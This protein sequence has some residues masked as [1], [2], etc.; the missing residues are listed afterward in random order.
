MK[1]TLIL[2]F[3]VFTAIGQGIK[4]TILD[5][6]TQKPLENVTIYYDKEKTGTASDKKGAFHLKTI[7]T[8]NPTDSIRFSIIG[9]TQKNYTLSTLNKLNFI[10]HLATITESLDEV[11]IT[12]KQHLN[13]TIAYKNLSP[14]VNGVYNFDATIIGNKIYII[15]GNETHFEDLG[16]RALHEAVSLDDFL[17][18]LKTN[19]TWENYSDKLQIYDIEKDTWNTLKLT[20][21][22]RANHSIAFLNNKIYVLGGKTLS[23]NR[24]REYLDDKI[25]VL[26]LDTKQLIVDNTNPHQAVNFAAFSYQD[27]IIV[28]GG[29]VKQNSNQQ[30]TYTDLSHIYN[31]ETGYWY[32]LPKMTKPKEVSGVIIKN[33]IY[34]IGG[35]NKIP[36]STIESYN[37]ITRKWK[38]EGDLFYGI[39]NPALTNNNGI[40]Y[41][42][43]D[44]KII[45]YNV[46]TKLLNEYSI[47]LHLKNA[48]ICYYRNNLYLLGG[49]IEDE[50]T[51]SPSARLYLIDINE[52]S[53]T[54]ILHS[55]KLKPI[56]NN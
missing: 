28:M 48:Q 5:K 33:N 47:D 51:K 1:L 38:N 19:F 15:G 43:N 50:Y 27:N 52:F 17:K 31:N 11:T 32:E 25:E 54:N 2:F 22:K 7:S 6:A 12:S 55:K 20:F 30:K 8:I 41:I 23:L 45:T 40:I 34:L 21:R 24:K 29:S 26:N 9:Y 56:A 16:K 36:I 10:V 3:S 53:K 18:K 14:L 4:G 39:E 35:F 46:A 13:A 42:F 37:L 44:D 49:L